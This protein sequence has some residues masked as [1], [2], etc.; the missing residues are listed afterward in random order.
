LRG[1][2]IL[3]Q[4]ESLEI[5]IE[6]ALAFLARDDQDYQ[7]DSVVQLLLESLDPTV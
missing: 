6:L 1:D 3:S 5:I 2:R 7:L 4:E